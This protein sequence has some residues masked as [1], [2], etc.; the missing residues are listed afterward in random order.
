[1][2]CSQQRENTTC[3]FSEQ[4]SDGISKP[5]ELMAV[6]QPPHP[7]AIV[8][9]AWAKY[10]VM[11]LAALKA[12]LLFYGPRPR[13]HVLGINKASSGYPYKQRI[14]TSRKWQWHA[15]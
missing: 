9:A 11:F 13:T 8:T 3:C 15:V 4:A 1:M 10:N 5:F 14:C 2:C 7:P 12:V 6:T